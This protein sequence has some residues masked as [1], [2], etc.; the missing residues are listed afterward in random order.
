VKK[1]VSQIINDE[2][3]TSSTKTTINEAEARRI[4]AQEFPLLSQSYEKAP[5][6]GRRGNAAPS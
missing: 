4:I 3:T 2:Q 5:D 6:W 1:E